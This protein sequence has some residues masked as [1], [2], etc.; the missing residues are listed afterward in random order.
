MEK[1]KKHFQSV[2]FKLFL[3]MCVTITIIVLC[4]VIINSVVLGSFYMY[5][6]TRTVR[7]V[8]NRINAFYNN[9]G[10]DNSIEDELRRIAFNNSFDIFIETQENV[11]VF[12]TDKDLYT[13]INMITNAKNSSNDVNVIFSD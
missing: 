13:T 3:T 2:R 7:N 6:K 4:L 11:I 5:S 12:S 10:N 8:Y 1:Q 9:N